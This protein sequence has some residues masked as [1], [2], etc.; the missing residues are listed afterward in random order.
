MF[1]FL[2]KGEEKEKKKDDSCGQAASTETLKAE[3]KGS[4]EAGQGT[5]I[6]EEAPRKGETSCVKGTNN[7][8]PNEGICNEEE[9]SDD[10]DDEDENSEE[11]HDDE[12]DD[13]DDDNDDDND[14]DNDDDEQNEEN[15]QTSDEVTPT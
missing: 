4:E 5:K 9:G 13:D 1:L 15:F 8:F 11:D 7:I 2:S 3:I 6:E 12:D 14:N 10:D